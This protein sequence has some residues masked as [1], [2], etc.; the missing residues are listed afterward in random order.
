M[1][2]TGHW[3]SG[4]ILMIWAVAGADAFAETIRGKSGAFSI[5]VPLR[6][7]VLGSVLGALFLLGVIV[8]VVVLVKTRK[9]ELGTRNSGF[10][11]G[12]ES[13]EENGREDVE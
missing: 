8:W 5:D 6:I 13:E 4:P 2:K 1:K 10:G 3:L 11:V 12:E 7:P 9:R